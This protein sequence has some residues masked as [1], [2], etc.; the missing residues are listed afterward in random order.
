MCEPRLH[1]VTPRPIADGADLHVGGYA[2]Q[3]LADFINLL[4]ENDD[5]REQFD[6]VL[7]GDKPN[8]DPHQIDTGSRDDQFSTDV[9]AALPEAALV[10]RVH[11]PELN[12][13]T[14]TLA[15]ICADQAPTHIDIPR[16]QNR[17]A[18]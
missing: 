11:G 1:R 12:V 3:F 10:I 13:L 6:Q 16:Q 18:A 8:D 17:R 2:R 5:L 7:D 9:V 4:A 14:D 15:D